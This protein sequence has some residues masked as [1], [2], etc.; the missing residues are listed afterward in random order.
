MDGTSVKGCPTCVLTNY[1]QPL[2]KCV[3]GSYAIKRV[4]VSSPRLWEVPEQQYV[5]TT[6]DWTM[7]IRITLW[8]FQQAIDIQSVCDVNTQC[9]HKCEYFLRKNLNEMLVCSIIRYYLVELTLIK[10]FFY[11]CLINVISIINRKFIT[12]SQGG[13]TVVYAGLYKD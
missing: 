9:I 5:L 2:S 3:T 10:M 6:I 8:W 12:A 7:K 13:R 4:N 1:Q 11:L